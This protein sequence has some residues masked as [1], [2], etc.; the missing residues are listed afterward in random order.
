MASKKRSLGPIRHLNFHQ[1]VQGML[2]QEDRLLKQTLDHLTRE[3][4]NNIRIITQ[5]QQVIIAKLK[6]L[7]QRLAASQQ[8]SLQALEQEERKKEQAS[9]KRPKSLSLT[10]KGNS[11]GQVRGNRFYSSFFPNQANQ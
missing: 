5:E 8:R 9:G 3:S 10:P 2:Q 11:A 7:E 4:T 1:H 6:L